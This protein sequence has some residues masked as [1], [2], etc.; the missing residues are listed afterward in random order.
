MDGRHHGLAAALDGH[1]HTVEIGRKW[2]LAKFTNVRAR[3]E[4]APGADDDHGAHRR[5]R[6]TPGD[7]V[8]QALAHAL[9]ERIDGRIVHGNHAHAALL[10]ECHDVAHFSPP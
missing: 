9:G 5:V 8:H 7:G 10:V 6:H 4:G 1:E 2:R 3:D